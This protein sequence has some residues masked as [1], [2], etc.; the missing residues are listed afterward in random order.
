M[1]TNTPDPHASWPFPAAERFQRTASPKPNN[2]EPSPEEDVP[3]HV[4][5]ELVDEQLERD[6]KASKAVDSK[7]KNG[8]HH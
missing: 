6:R 3:D 1:T 5:Q 2:E 8:S 7:V 4:E